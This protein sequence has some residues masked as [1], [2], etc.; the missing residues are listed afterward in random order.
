MLWRIPR[1]IGSELDIERWDRPCS[2][3]E[4]IK[5]YREVQSNCRYHLPS[6][7]ILSKK[8]STTYLLVAHPTLFPYQCQFPL[9]SQINSRN[10]YTFPYPESKLLPSRN[11]LLYTP[12][13][14]FL[15][16]SPSRTNP[17]PIFKNKTDTHTPHNHQ[18][19]KRAGNMEGRQ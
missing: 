18:K 4:L 13:C 3:L 10:K 1:G 19:R 2:S 16:T 6:V 15:L 11:I 17:S 9:A 12:R 8:A 14:P 7:P 5:Q